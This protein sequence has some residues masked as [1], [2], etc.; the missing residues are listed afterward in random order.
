MK[1]QHI[2]IFLAV[3]LIGNTMQGQLLEK[4]KQRAKERGMETSNEVKYDSTAYDPTMATYNDEEIEDLEINTPSDFFTMDVVMELYHAEGHL[5]QTSYFDKETIVMQTDN[6]VNIKPIYH[7]RI[8]KF[9]AFS[10]EDNRYESMSLLPGSSMGFM[11]SG[12]TTQVYKLPQQPYFQAYNAL[13]KLDIAMNFLIL[14]MAFIYKPEHFV[15]DDFYRP[16]KISCRD[17]TCT[18]FSYNDFEYEGSYIQF[19]SQGRL[20]EL[21]ITSTNNQFTDSERNPSG[22]FKFYYDKQIEVSLPENV[23]ERSLVP[24]P[25]GKIIPLEK[26]LEPWKHNKKDKQKN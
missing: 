17:D 21:Y 16:S 15:N 9:Y 10:V 1:A 6:K 2:I 22:K 3:S 4:L 18:R 19:D 5:V 7:D 24:G 23:Y 26:G 25:L 14:E 12:M 13:S 8:G 20:N 11:T